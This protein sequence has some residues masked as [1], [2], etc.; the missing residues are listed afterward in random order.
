[1]VNLYIKLLETVELSDKAPSNSPILKS[2]K[3]F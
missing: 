1:M 2:E 3:T